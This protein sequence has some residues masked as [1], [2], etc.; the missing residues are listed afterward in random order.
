M[1]DVDD[2][3]LRTDPGAAASEQGPD[4]VLHEHEPKG[5]SSSGRRALVHHTPA[6]RVA[7]G[8]D[9]AGSI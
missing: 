5:K 3:L 6:E 2:D 9:T 1:T 4:H 7:R 8:K